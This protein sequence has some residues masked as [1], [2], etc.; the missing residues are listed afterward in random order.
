MQGCGLSAEGRTVPIHTVPTTTA[1][2][3]R[4]GATPTPQHRRGGGGVPEHEGGSASGRGLIS[5][6]SPTAHSSL[7]QIH[8]AGEGGGR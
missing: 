4:G 7:L 2:P 5:A 8:G 6:W 1:L 3:Q